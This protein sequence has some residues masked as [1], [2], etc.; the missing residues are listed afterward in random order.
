[1]LSRQ[2]SASVFQVLVK[3]EGRVKRMASHINVHVLLASKEVTVKVCSLSTFGIRDKLLF[4][5]LPWRA[6]KF[7]A[8][9]FKSPERGLWKV[10]LQTPLF[11]SFLS[12]FFY[13][14]WYQDQ[15]VWQSQP[16]SIKLATDTMN[17]WNSS[18]FCAGT[19]TY[20]FVSKP[21]LS[22]NIGCQS[23]NTRTDLSPEGLN[24]FL[25]V[26]RTYYF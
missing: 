10:C 15:R 4:L 24:G 8:Q 9:I 18:F 3:M 20:I 26:S 16:G 22:I 17:P 13:N 12:L 5:W 14:L 25:L 7:R 1:M 23:E 6:A 11:L 21:P 19:C 2:L